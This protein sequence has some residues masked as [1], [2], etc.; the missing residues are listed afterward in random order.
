ME[1]HHGLSR[2]RG[3]GDSGGAV[4]LPLNV[5]ALEGV[6][7]HTPPLP[8]VVEGA[9]QFLDVVHD[10]EPALGIRVLEGI[11]V[12]HCRHRLRHSARG[13]L[14][15]RLGGFLREMLGQI[16]QA[17]LRGA[18]CVME[19]F[20][21]N[22][23]PQQGLGID[24]G[25]QGRLLGHRHLRRDGDRHLLNPF[26]DLD[27]LGRAG[28]RVGL[29][30]S[31]LGPLVGVVVVADMDQKQAG[32]GPVDDQPDVPVHP[33]RPEVRVPGPVELVE[34][35]PGRGGIGLE[36][37]HGDLHRLLLLVGQAVQ[38]RVEGISG[39]EFHKRGFPVWIPI[40]NRAADESVE[41]AKVRPSWLLAGPHLERIALQRLFGGAKNAALAFAGRTSTVAG[42]VCR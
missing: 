20:L 11:D 37:E 6:E 19:P 9:F 23:V 33:H 28:P 22:P 10:P 2:A 36:I 35:Q 34:A 1:R 41:Q 3:P 18:Q 12:C 42:G 32:R 39:A 4:V 25:E 29:D 7:K 26:P 38:A 27:Q 14:Q 30:L 13:K 31:A 40:H 16:E 5:L 17:A 21:G 24:I 8:R 15:Q